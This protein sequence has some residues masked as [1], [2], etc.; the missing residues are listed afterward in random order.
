MRTKQLFGLI[1]SLQEKNYVTKYTRGYGNK[2]L[3]NPKG[4]KGSTFGPANKGRRFTKSEI[5]AYVR[6]QKS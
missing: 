5:E 1:K 4:F 2:P 6:D 3:N